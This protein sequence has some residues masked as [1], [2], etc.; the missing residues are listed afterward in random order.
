MFFINSRINDKFFNDSDKVDADYNL[1]YYKSY[2]RGVF[3]TNSNIYNKRLFVLFANRL[4]T[5]ST[6]F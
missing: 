2:T 6:R 4:S 3:R 1:F 5:G